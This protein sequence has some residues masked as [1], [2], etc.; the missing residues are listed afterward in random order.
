[1][2]NYWQFVSNFPMP[3]WF[4]VKFLRDIQSL[5]NSVSQKF[6]EYEVSCSRDTQVRQKSILLFV[7][8]STFACRTFQ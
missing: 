5:D 6:Q 2:T 3:C 4:T 7:R 8:K 1:L